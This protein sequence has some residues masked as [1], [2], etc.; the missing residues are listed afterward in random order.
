MFWKKVWSE[1]VVNEDAEE[2]EIWKNNCISKL[3]IFPWLKQDLWCIIGGKDWHLLCLWTD[4]MDDLSMV[5]TV[6][7]GV[8]FVEHPCSLSTDQDVTVMKPAPRPSGFGD[9]SLSLTRSE[10]FVYWWITNINQIKAI[11]ASFFIPHLKQV[12]PPGLQK[13]YQVRFASSS[14]ALANLEHISWPGESTTYV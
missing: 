5:W 3:S 1:K 11:I 13:H 14:A 9:S 6:C 4:V 2:F 8:E 12:D 7:D 10:K